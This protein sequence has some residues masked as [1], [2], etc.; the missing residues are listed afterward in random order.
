MKRSTKPTAY[1]L[2]KACT[3]SEWDPID[4][5]VIHLTEL[6]KNNLRQRLADVEHFKEDGSFYNLTYWDSSSGFYC[7]SKKGTAKILREDEDWS[8]VDLDAE[9]ERG[10]TVPENQLEAHQLM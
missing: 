4:F 3:N 7:N 8:F 9:E 2:I 6:F 5:A 10:F 1:I